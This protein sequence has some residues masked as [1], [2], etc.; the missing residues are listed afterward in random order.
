MSNSDNMNRQWK[1]LEQRIQFAS[2]FVI[3]THQNPD[4]DGLG[5]ELALYHLLKKLGKEVHIFNI[6]PT[7]ESLKFMDPDILCQR[8]IP[9][10][11]RDLLSGVDMLFVLDAGSF[12]RIGQMG[13]DAVAAKRA[14]IS[15][16]HHPKENNPV[17]LQEIVNHHDCS[18]G[19]LIYEFIKLCYPEHMDKIIATLLYTAIAGDTGN[20]RFG[21]TTSI[22][23]AVVSELLKYDIDVYG[24]YINLFGNISR[25]GTRLFST[26]LQNIQFSEDGR[27]VWF[28]ITREMLSENGA[29][30]MDTEG[31]T[32]F[33]RM[34]DGVEV[35]IMFKERLDGSTR[36]NFRSKGT[37]AT[38]GVARYFGGGGHVHASGI[39]SNR[40]LNEVYP[41]VVEAMIKQ[42]KETFHEN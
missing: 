32:D 27:I 19:K 10:Q 4:A 5:S 13:P 20:F 2:S 23:H 21:N 14:I 17:Y 24:T 9:S 6:S 29:G 28:I 36:I 3:T 1:E 38:N 11:H 40:V 25:S 16:D 30:D 8:Y 39:V 12:L 15:I 26:I 22:S 41:E 18:V 37:V 35:A 42:V 34:I 33:M 7:P 31:V